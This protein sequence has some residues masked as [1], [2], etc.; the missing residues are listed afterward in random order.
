MEA[1]EREGNAPDT[2]HTHT[3]HTHNIHTHNANT[4][5][6]GRQN[7]RACIPQKKRKEVEITSDK[8]KH[9]DEEKKSGDETN[10]T[11][12]TD[13]TR[14]HEHAYDAQKRA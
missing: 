7:A 5:Q 2:T 11:Q 6:Q 13:T 14:R 4:R 12:D 10:K 1:R 3:L 9:D 8:R